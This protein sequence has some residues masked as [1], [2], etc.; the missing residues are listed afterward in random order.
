M[1]LA[2]TH[3]NFLRAVLADPDLWMKPEVVDDFKYYSYILCY[4]DDIMVIHHDVRPVLDLVDKYMKLK[5]SSVGDPDI[6]LGAKI[7]KTKTPNGVYAWEISPSKYVQEAVK[8]CEDYLKKTYPNDYELIK[9]A[10]NPISME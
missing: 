5:E 10:L 4:V 7:R 6:Y 9:N 3:A 2:M 1:A 8:N